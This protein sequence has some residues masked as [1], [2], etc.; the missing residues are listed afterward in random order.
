MSP[1]I[2]HYFTVFSRDLTDLSDMV[3]NTIRDACL[4]E[5]ALRRPLDKRCPFC[6]NGGRYFGAEV[7]LRQH[8]QLQHPHEHA[9]IPSADHYLCTLC[10]ADLRVF[11]WKDLKRHVMEKH[12]SPYLAERTSSIPT[13]FAFFSRSFRF[14]K[15]AHGC[16]FR[17]FHYIISFHEQSRYQPI[18]SVIRILFLLCRVSRAFVVKMVVPPGSRSRG[19]YDAPRG[20]CGVARAQRCDSPHGFYSATSLQ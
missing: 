13:Q 11:Q 19:S 8:I 9:S 6:P 20:Y 4:A 12:S 2:A 14:R 10:P 5:V 7:R 18:P 17:G 1:T 16:G 3:W 15:I